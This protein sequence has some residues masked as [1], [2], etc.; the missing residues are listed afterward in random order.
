MYRKKKNRLALEHMKSAG[1]GVFFGLLVPIEKLAIGFRVETAEARDW[2]AVLPPE[3]VGRPLFVGN[4]AFNFLA[5]LLGDRFCSD[6]RESLCRRID[7]AGSDESSHDVEQG[8]FIPWPDFCAVSP[9]LDRFIGAFP[10]EMAIS[11]QECGCSGEAIDWWQGLKL[12]LAQPRVFLMSKLGESLGRLCKLISE[13]GEEG[14]KQRNFGKLGGV[15]I[16]R[17]S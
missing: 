12:L 17:F 15:G 10:S 1:G 3:G 16:R 13:F 6:A 8:S 14:S 5:E 11:E 9:G 7:P 2:D 4:I